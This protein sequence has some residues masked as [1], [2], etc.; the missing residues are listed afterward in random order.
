MYNSLKTK[1]D[2]IN[3][4]LD[5]AN[6]VYDPCGMAQGLSLGMVDMDLIRDIEVQQTTDNAWDVTL[7]V[8]LT[9]PD[10]M[11]FI[12]FEQE[13]HRQLKAFPEIKTFKIE[14]DKNFDWTPD[15]LNQAARSQIQQ[16]YD[17]FLAQVKN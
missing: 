8:R 6:L 17:R 2:V 5:S 14:W 12:Y 15:N 1:T 10:C 4:V 7:R 13:I 9:S 16:R 11:Y 3:L